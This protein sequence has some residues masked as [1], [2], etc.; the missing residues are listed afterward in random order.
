M[1]TSG[2][3]SAQIAAITTSRKG[4]PASTETINV[5]P[6]GQVAAFVVDSRGRGTVVFQD[7]SPL[8]LFAAYG[9]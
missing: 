5:A 2:T 4:R 8:H 6:A 3:G 1:L 9:H 7:F